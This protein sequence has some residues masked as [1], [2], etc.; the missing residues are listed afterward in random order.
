[1]GACHETAGLEGDELVRVVPVD[2]QPMRLLP[3]SH[4]RCG[5]LGMTETPEQDE[6]SLPG[7]F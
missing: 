6:N 4:R 2:E 1:M 3:K 7:L 5:S